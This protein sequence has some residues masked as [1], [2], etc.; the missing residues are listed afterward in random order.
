[1]TQ[2]IR[3]ATYLDIT[4][5]GGPVDVCEHIKL[6]SAYPEPADA[7]E[8]TQQLQIRCRECGETYE[9]TIKVN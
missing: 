9:Y 6:P 2:S 5:R 1:M 3:T 4:K 8:Y 7:C